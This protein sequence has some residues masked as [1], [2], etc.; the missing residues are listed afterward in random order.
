MYSIDRDI[1]AGEN[2]LELRWVL[3]ELSHAVRICR[4]VGTIDIEIVDP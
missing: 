1:A 3:V 4:C 2:T